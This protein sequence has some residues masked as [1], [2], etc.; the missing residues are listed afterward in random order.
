MTELHEQLYEGEHRSELSLEHPFKPHMTIA[1]YDERTVVEQIDVSSAGDFPIKAK[2]SALE[3][4]RL[5]DGNLT[6][7]KTVPF[8]L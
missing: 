8:M 2:V 5:S 3:L 1:S 4:V 7:L 6:T